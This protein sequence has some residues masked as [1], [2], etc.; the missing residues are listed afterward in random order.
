MNT[1]LEPKTTSRDEK[2]SLGQMEREDVVWQASEAVTSLIS[3]IWAVQAH[4]ACT[5]LSGRGRVAGGGSNGLPLTLEDFQ[6]GGENR[7]RNIQSC[8]LELRAM[9]K[10]N[11]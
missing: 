9:F 5:H 1:F 2:Q 7:G 6:F 4:A 8:Q 11:K 10:K 3:I